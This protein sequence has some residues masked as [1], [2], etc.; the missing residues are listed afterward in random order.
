[1]SKKKRKRSYDIV[2]S[3][4]LPTDA[5]VL[6]ERRIQVASKVASL[7][8]THGILQKD[9]AEESG[10]SPAVMS[11]TLSGLKTRTLERKLDAIEKAIEKLT[12]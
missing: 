8:F 12:A 4:P 10:L 2:S 5:S 9:I 11:S 7:K 6:R 1:M 3:V